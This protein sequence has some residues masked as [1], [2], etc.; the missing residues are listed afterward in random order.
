MAQTIIPL[1]GGGAAADPEADVRFWDPYDNTIVASYSAADFAN[2]SALPENPTHSGL[3]SQGWN[4]T[5]ADAKTQVAWSGK[6]DIGQQ[7]VTSDGKTRLYVTLDSYNLSPK[8]VIG[9]NGTV[10]I[11][12]GDGTTA[13]TQSASGSSFPNTTFSHTYSAAGDYVITISK[14]SGDFRLRGTQYGS[15]VFTNNK[16]TIYSNCQYNSC[17]KRIE[18]GSGVIIHDYAFCYLTVLSSV[19]IPTDV[20]F[21]GAN[22][23]YGSAVQFCSFP[24]GIT[25]ILGS[26]FLECKSLLS[27]SLPKS[28]LTLGNSVFNSCSALRRA[29]LP[30][31]MTSLGTSCFYL[32][33]ALTD[34]AIPT[35]IS[36]IPNSMM[37]STNVGS[38]TIPSGV[39]SIGSG[40]FNKCNALESVTVADSVTEI[41]ST[42][43]AYDRSLKSV[44]LSSAL[45]TI[46]NSAFYYSALSHVTIPATVTSIGS[47]AFG[48]CYGLQEIRFAGSTPPTVGSGGFSSL[49]TTCKIYVP[50]GSLSAY[51]STANM[52]SSSTYTY[53]EY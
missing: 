5:L 21:S 27:V 42:A 20:T 43:F 52:P 40:V 6:L 24:S 13:D 2:L 3:T 31:V 33:Y 32:C 36:E 34:L 25:E 8:I 45:T 9:L 41:K 23:F 7:Y 53:I 11:D 50:S 46:G 51:T 12:W 44:Q 16:T 18:I 37:D 38:V 39:T 17:V 30:K 1:P 29:I 49:P 26:C 28:V 15:G 19:T 48:V 10:T 14:D 35:G 22:V 4:W 47:S